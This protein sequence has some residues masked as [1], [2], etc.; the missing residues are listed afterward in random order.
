[1]SRYARQIGPARGR[2]AGQARLAAARVLVVGAGGLGVA[3]AAVPRR[4]GGRPITIV[5]PDLVDE[6]NLHRQPLYREPVS[7]VPRPGRRR[8]ARRL[9]PE[10]AIDARR[11]RL[12][13][14]NAPALVAAADLVLDCADSFAATYALSDACL[15]PASP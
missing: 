6:S 15:A 2:R 9:N 3:G 7:G 5:D 8:A 11:A 1:M 4:R 12:D 14:A 13:P 10:I